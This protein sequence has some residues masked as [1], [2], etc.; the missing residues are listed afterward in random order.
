MESGTWRYQEICLVLRD[1]RIS[2][3][4]IRGLFDFMDVPS[5]VT[6]NSRNKSRSLINSVSVKMCQS[7]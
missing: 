7:Y 3:F 5:T 6:D 4:R 2:E 1:K